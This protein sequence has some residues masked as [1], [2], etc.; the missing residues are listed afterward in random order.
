MK[1]NFY[2]FL[3]EH[4][5]DQDDYEVDFD[6][7]VMNAA[8]GFETRRKAALAYFKPNR[9]NSLNEPYVCFHDEFK[10]KFEEFGIKEAYIIEQDFDG[11]G[12]NIYEIYDNYDEAL[13]AYNDLKGSGI[14]SIDDLIENFLKQLR[15]NNLH[16]LDIVVDVNEEERG[17]DFSFN[18]RDYEG[19]YNIINEI[20]WLDDEDVLDS[21][22]DYTKLK[23]ALENDYGLYV[24]NLEIMP[25]RSG[26]YN[27]YYSAELANKD[28]NGSIEV[29]LEYENGE[30]KADDISKINESF[31]KLQ[32][33][34]K[35]KEHEMNM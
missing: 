26:F 3:K 32:E 2:K 27:R 35:K 24:L 14:L 11:D 22:K 19:G 18:I 10:N 28:I 21:L 34:N 9:S 7:A 1:K 17:E 12:D 30:I 8:I 31:K 29:D 16:N 15:E 25:Q 20:S 5:L 6:N 33:E 13:A 4:E 23:A